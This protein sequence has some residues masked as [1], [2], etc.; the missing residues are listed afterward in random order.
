MP[1]VDEEILG[2]KTRYRRENNL[3]LIRAVVG[4]ADGVV[5][6]PT[7]PGF[8]W[9][10]LQTSNGLSAPR[11]V[12]GP[13]G[14]AMSLQAGAAVNL[15]Y[16]KMGQLRVAEP[17][18][19]TVLAGGGNPIAN[20][21][22]PTTTTVPRMTQGSIET[23]RV[24]PSAPASLI[25]AVKAWH[26]LVS[27]TAYQFAGAQVDLTSY[28]PSSGNMCYAVIFVKSDYS[29]IEVFAST[30]RGVADLPLDVADIQECI[31]AATAGSTPVWAIKLVG[32]QTTITQDNLDLDGVDL[33]QM[34]NVAS[35]GGG[36]SLTVEEVD[37]TPTVSNVTT[38]VVSNGTLTDDGG[39]QVTINTGGGGSLTVEEVDGTPTVSGV[40]TIVV[41]N[42]TLTD[43]GG[44]QVTIDTSGGSA[45]YPKRATMWAD[46]FNTSVAVT[47]AHDTAQNYSTY[48]Y[49][50]S[51]ADTQEYT[52]SFMLVGGTYNLSILAV[53]YPDGGKFDVYIDGATVGTTQDLY[54]G[55]GTYNVVLT[56]SSI[57]VTGDGYHTL[58]LKVNGK[59]ASST[60][61][62][63]YCTKV[64]I[65][66]SAD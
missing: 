4:T 59:N 2:L 61:Y 46:E 36:G 47:R 42:G 35:S 54:A 34:V 66:P 56:L 40:T 21:V 33:R 55:S 51:P 39:G 25:V 58:K 64:W 11:R 65:A 19:L 63:L 24:I 62:Y 53:K 5:I 22:Q 17:D 9:V 48:I 8:I 27:G 1:T 14:K 12:L 26:P 37:G 28:V 10:R 32:G 6:D 49:Q 50:N 15:E 18:N 13:A 45:T 7:A 44:G 60:N 29:T 20:I 30:A 57:T 41:S 52:S 31:T 38:I 3:D 23:L 16:D 43:D